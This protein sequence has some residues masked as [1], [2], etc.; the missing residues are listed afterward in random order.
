M[1]SLYGK[2]L[3]FY[4]HKKTAALTLRSLFLSQCKPLGAT[5]SIILFSTLYHFCTGRV[6]SSS[7]SIDFTQLR[8]IRLLFPLDCCRWFTCY[9][10]NYSVYIFY[11]VYYSY[12]NSVKYFVWYSCPVCCHKVCCCNRS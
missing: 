3:V 10:V 11:F 4:N 8:K 6:I 1:Y 5:I 7:A 9:I 2:Q 12:G